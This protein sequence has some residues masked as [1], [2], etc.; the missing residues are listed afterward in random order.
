MTTSAAFA[1]VSRRAQ[2]ERMRSAGRVALTQYGVSATSLRLLNH[3]YN[4]TFRVETDES[5]FAL[6]IS[7]NSR[8]S[9]AEV[10]SELTWLRALQ[11]ETEVCVADPLT[12]LSGDPVA[13]VRVSGLE[14][15]SPAALF[16]WL[17]GPDI[18]DKINV[19]EA[20]EIGRTA[21]ALHEHAR[22]WTLPDATEF[23]DIGG[24]FMDD[25]DRL[26]T[27]DAVG[28]DDTQVAFLLDARDHIEAEIADV[29]AAETL[30]IHADLHP[31]NVKWADDRLAVFDFDDCGMGSPVQDLAIA[32]FYLR[33]R[34]E[35]RSALFDGYATTA[36]VPPHTTDQFEALLASRNLLLLNDLIASVTGDRSDFVQEYALRTVDRQRHYMD[37]GTYRHAPPT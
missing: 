34:P 13:T 17:A 26:A 19:Q 14:R 12:P 4:S 10:G 3:D 2:I 9:A 15:E 1:S 37:T 8:R 31:W 11:R 18:G 25:V 36:A 30:L 16:A 5:R 33:D 32:A 35:L 7:M 22:R 24:L 29:F 23:R 21:A 20:T 28:L 6:R 27:V